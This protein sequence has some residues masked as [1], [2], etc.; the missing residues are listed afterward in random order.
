MQMLR[1]SLT[2]VRL[3][4][5][6]FGF[7]TFF[8]FLM[9]AFP[10]SGYAS[11]MN[12]KETQS[13]MISPLEQSKVYLARVDWLLKEAVA[14]AQKA[15]SI[16]SQAVKQNTVMPERFNYA[17]LTSDI[18]IIRAALA[19]YINAR[20]TAPESVQS[21]NSVKEM[22]QIKGDYAVERKRNNLNKNNTQLD[23][24]GGE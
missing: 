2:V 21:I 11:A 1:P 17:Y 7:F 18:E 12:S 8:T 19:N 15:Q 13:T 4:F 20:S 16:E 5:G 23:V 22:A 9:T 10:L 3:F 6:F 14:M 24:L